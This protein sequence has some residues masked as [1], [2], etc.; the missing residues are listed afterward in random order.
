MLPFLGQRQPFRSFHPIL[1]I[2]LSFLSW[3][4]DN[5]SCQSFYPSFPGSKTTFPFFS[6]DPLNPFILPFLVQIQYILKILL[7]FLSW[8]KDNTSSQSFYASFSGS[9]TTFPFFSPDPVNPFI[10][11]F[12]V[13]RQYILSILLSFLSWFKDNLSFLFTRSSQSFYPSFPGSKTIHP[14][15][16]FILPFL[17]QRQHILP[18][19]LSFI[20]YFKDNPSLQPFYHS[21]TC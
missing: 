5:T 6:P 1:S 17:V 13:Q 3:F 19:L 16:P 7:S 8:F 2:L 4:K 12:L 20:S 18:I 14:V 21:S 10:L 9:K 15:N 11:P